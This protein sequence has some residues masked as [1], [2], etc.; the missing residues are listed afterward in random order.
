M[1]ILHLSDT[2]LSGAP[3]RLSKLISK[4]T[5]HE[6]RF[7]VGQRKI[8][9]RVFPADLVA[10]EMKDGELEKWLKWADVI[11]Y[12]NRWKRQ[13]IFKRVP[14]VKKPS[15][16]QIHSPR[17]EEGHHEEVASGVPLAIIAQYHVRQWPELKFIIPNVVDIYDPLHKPQ[18]RNHEQWPVVSYAPSSP[19]GRGWNNKSYTTVS[20]VLKRKHFAREIYYQRI[21][22]M[23]FEECMKAKAK[24]DIGIDEVSTGSYHMSS[25]EYLSL[26]VATIGHLDSLTEKVVKD[27]TGADW[28]PWVDCRENDFKHTLEMLIK[29]KNYVEHGARA[30]KWMETYWSPQKL[31]P[32]FIKMYEAL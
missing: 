8:F 7:I 20:P 1:K 14:F 4:Y 31:V 11:H 18:Q 25:L 21:V 27:L 12:H 17:E 9:N 32:H 10:E 23:P 22:N 24:A 15:V 2:S 19:G 26:G 5:E 16:I 13:A 28:L 3:L 30:R 29:N 6:S